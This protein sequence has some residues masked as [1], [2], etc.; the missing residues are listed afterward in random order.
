[1]ADATDIADRATWPLDRLWA[2]RDLK[3]RA[4]L[5]HAKDHSSWHAERLAA[6]DPETVSGQDLSMI[7]VMTKA[8]LMENWDQIVTVPELTLAKAEAHVERMMSEG[9]SVL[10]G[11]F[12]V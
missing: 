4:L 9:G 7:P 10:D 12:A 6:I 2:A 11:R 8:D 5:R 1:M 3:L